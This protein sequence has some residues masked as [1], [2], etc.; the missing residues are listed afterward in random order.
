MRWG[1]LNGKQWGWRWR[2]EYLVIR[3]LPYKKRQ[4]GEVPVSGK[5]KYTS[6]ICHEPYTDKAHVLS[7]P[8]RRKAALILSS[9]GRNS[10]ATDRDQRTPPLTEKV[11]LF[12]ELV[13]LPWSSVLLP[14][15]WI[16]FKGVYLQLQEFPI[17]PRLG[18]TISD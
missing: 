12:V 2:S 4:M 11:L 9:T 5:Q 18:L 6:L 8:T 1:R 10:R 7:S 13:D 3:H 16:T 15:R 14:N 17:L